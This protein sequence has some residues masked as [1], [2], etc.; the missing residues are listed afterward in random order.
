MNECSIRKDRETAE[1]KEKEEKI[2]MRVIHFLNFFSACLLCFAVPR[3]C[4]YHLSHAVLCL[5]LLC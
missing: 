3:F 4:D 5:C 2:T 1:N